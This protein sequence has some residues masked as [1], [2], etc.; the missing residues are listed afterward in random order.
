MTIDDMQYIV[1]SSDLSNF[2]RYSPTITKRFLEVGSASAQLAE[3]PSN[4]V[5]GN[6]EV[7]N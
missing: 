4:K 7:K 6:R 5:E 3:I 2:S 1:M